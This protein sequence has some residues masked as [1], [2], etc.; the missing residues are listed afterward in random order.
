MKHWSEE[1][2]VNGVTIKFKLDT[3]AYVTVIGDSIYSRFFSKTNLQRAHKKK[4]YGPC[5]SKLYGLGILQA[6]LRLNG[7]SCGEDIHVVEHLETPLF[8]RSACLALDTVAKVVTVTQ[9]ADDYKARFPNVFNGL[10]RMDGEYEIKMT[11]CHEPFNQT[12]PRGVP[13]PLLPNVKD[14]LDRMETM[15]VIDKVDAATEWCSPI[16]VV[17]KPNGKVRICG[18]F[19]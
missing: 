5:K 8:G 3:G 16:A 13:I 10:G 1:I 4:L 19:T 9:S 12:T 11:P 2:E 18:D 15:G 7:E 17:P 6:K 14:E